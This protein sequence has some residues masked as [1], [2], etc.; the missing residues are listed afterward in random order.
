MATLNYYLDKRSIKK[1]DK[2]RI[3]EWLSVRLQAKNILV[4]NQ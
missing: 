3:R 1:D 4:V 2:E